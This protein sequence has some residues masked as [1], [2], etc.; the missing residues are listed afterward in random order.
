MRRPIAAS[1]ALLL[2]SSLMTGCGSLFPSGPR[3][4]EVILKVRGVAAEKITFTISEDVK[5]PGTPRTVD[6]PALPW[7]DSYVPEVAS[8]GSVDLT[9]VP[10]GGR[11]T[12]EIIVSKKQ[13]AKQSGEPGKPLVCGTRLKGRR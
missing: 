4:Y 9:V 5:S 11:A 7:T 2:A 1:A 10:Q 13:A 6:H 12:C 3:V 8:L